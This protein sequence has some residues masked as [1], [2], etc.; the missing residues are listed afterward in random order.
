MSSVDALAKWLY[1]RPRAEGG[2]TKVLQ[3]RLDQDSNRTLAYL[4]K[5]FG[6]P[7]A[8]VAQELLRAAM[9][10]TLRAIPGNKIELE[11]DELTNDMVE[12]RVHDFS[13]IKDDDDD[14]P[15]REV[16]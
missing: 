6:M 1:E 12:V 11:Y 14:A 3:I 4:S 10:D 5:R 16:S 13:S 7:K 8:T 2:P 15:V 9:K